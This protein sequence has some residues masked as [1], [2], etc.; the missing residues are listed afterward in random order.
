[1][2]PHGL[3]SVPLTIV[4][5][6]Q[7]SSADTLPQQD[8]IA[9]SAVATLFFAFPAFVSLG[10]DPLGHSTDLIRGLLRRRMKEKITFVR[11]QDFAQNSI[12]S[13]NKFTAIAQCLYKHNQ[14]SLS[15]N[16]LL[17]NFIIK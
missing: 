3:K 16:C 13:G 9:T 11:I 10:R 6:C 14:P 15:P 12:V 8:Y 17:L 1:M 7:G 4:C 5:N 2:E